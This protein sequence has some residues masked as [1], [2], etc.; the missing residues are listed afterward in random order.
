LTTAPQQPPSQDA[1]EEQSVKVR[2]GWLHATGTQQSF[3]SQL[4]PFEHV[5][6]QKRLPGSQF[7]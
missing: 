2:H 5:L 7:V 6:P 3:G 4:L 1:P